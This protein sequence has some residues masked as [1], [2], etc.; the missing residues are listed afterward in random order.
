ME[1]FKVE[2]IIMHEEL[3]KELIFLQTGGIDPNTNYD[4]SGV[5]QKCEALQ[6]I[7]DFLIKISGQIDKAEEST[8]LSL[9]QDIMYLKQSFVSLGAISQEEKGGRYELS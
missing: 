3:I 6:D 2:D 9:L 8:V 5:D 1:T 7:S 4:N